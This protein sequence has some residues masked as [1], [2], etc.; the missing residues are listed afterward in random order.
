MTRQRDSDGTAAQQDGGGPAVGG[1]PPQYPLDVPGCGHEAGGD[2]PPVSGRDGRQRRIQASTQRTY[3]AALWLLLETTLARAE[4][5]ARIPMPRVP[6]KMP[7]ILSGNEVARVIAGL[8]S[9]RYR[10]ILTAASGAG[11]RISEV[12]WPPS[13]SLSAGGSKSTT[14]D[15]SSSAR[16]RRR[17]HRTSASLMAWHSSDVPP[18]VG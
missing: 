11:L 12:P 16:L 2:S 18:I 14:P 9:A 3:G 10:A 6:R 4:V 1:A 15:T 17:R 13:A 5:V 8:S 7:Q